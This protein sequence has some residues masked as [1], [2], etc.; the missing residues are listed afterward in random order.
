[1]FDE[2]NFHIV[3]IYSLFMT[4]K[5]IIIL[6]IFLLKSYKYI[7]IHK[8][9]YDDDGNEENRVISLIDVHTHTHA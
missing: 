2:N 3:E 1:M 5:K 9:D 6:N 4:N 7:A 8:I